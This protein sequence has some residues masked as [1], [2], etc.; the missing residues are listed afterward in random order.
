MQY[1]VAVIVSVVLG[2]VI[3]A[4]GIVKTSRARLHVSTVKS[5]VSTMSQ[6]QLAVGVKECDAPPE[7]GERSKHD[8]DFCAEVTRAL[9]DE[10]LQIVQVPQTTSMPDPHPQK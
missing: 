10:P 9:D 4:D 1:R 8:A 5:K 7:S 2:A 6:R 3:V